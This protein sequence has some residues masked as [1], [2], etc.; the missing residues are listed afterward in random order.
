MPSEPAPADA[1]PF[2]VTETEVDDAIAACD[3][4]LRATVRA[5]LVGQAFMEHENSRMT[6]AGYRRLPPKP[7]KRAPES[8][9]TLPLARLSDVQG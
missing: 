5:L 6:S 7:R 1:N 9:V 4:D 8:N 3:G 2:D